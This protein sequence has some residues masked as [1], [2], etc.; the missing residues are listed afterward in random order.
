MALLAFAGGEVTAVETAV[1]ET[2]A[3]AV[4][5]ASALWLAAGM[6]VELETDA[7]GGAVVTAVA[8]AGVASESAGVVWALAGSAD[9]NK[10]SAKTMPLERLA[11]VLW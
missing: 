1:V 7:S 10:M 11:R 4:M 3:V 9:N 5:L 8:A 2:A 6:L